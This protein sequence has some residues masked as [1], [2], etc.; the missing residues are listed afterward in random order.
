MATE[1]TTAVPELIPT[2]VQT[3]KWPATYHLQRSEL[4]GGGFPFPREDQREGHCPTRALSQLTKPY[5]TRNRLCSAEKAPL[6]TPQPPKQVPSC[7]CVCAH[8][9][10]HTHTDTHTLLC[11]QTQGPPVRQR[12]R[13][14]RIKVTA[15]DEVTSIQPTYWSTQ[16]FLPTSVFKIVVEFKSTFNFKR[17]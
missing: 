5:S 14:W 3:R 16:K 10:T 2:Q 4:L 1:V 6:V 17:S 7:V 15:E 11:Y 9:H 8:T 13:A 12:R